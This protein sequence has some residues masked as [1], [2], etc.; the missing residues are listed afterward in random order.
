MHSNMAACKFHWFYTTAAT[1]RWLIGR[2][3]PGKLDHINLWLVVRVRST[4]HR[5]KKMILD[6]ADK[7]L[8]GWLQEQC[9]ST[10][11]MCI[12]AFLMTVCQGYISYV[13]CPLLLLGFIAKSTYSMISRQRFDKEDRSVS[14]KSIVSQSEYRSSFSCRATPSKL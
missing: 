2:A 4:Q 5:Q 10:W 14:Q 1:F 13:F 12:R 7:S 3:T 6:S 11:I 8:V 9:P